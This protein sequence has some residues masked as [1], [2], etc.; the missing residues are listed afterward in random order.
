MPSSQAVTSAVATDIG[1]EATY[2][3]FLNQ[4]EWRIPFCAGCGKPVFFPRV[5][6]LACGGQA[7]DWRAPSGL[8]TIYSTTVMRRA[9]EAGG[10]ANLCLVDLDEG[11]RMMTRVE[12]VS[13]EVPRIGDRVRARLV[14]VGDE[15]VVVFVLAQ[16]R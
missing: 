14:H 3:R 4:G 15:P 10:D 9:P 12:D 1:P 2:F 13:P 8:G 6:C 11:V 5:S 7:F 16:E